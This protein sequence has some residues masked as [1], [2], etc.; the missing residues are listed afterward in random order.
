MPM[1]NQFLL[2]KL[3]RL[4]QFLFFTSIFSAACALVLCW[5]SECLFVGKK[6]QLFSVLHVFVVA[7]TLVV[8]NVHYLIKKFTAP[9]S[10]QN[11]WVQGN[12]HFNYIFLGLGLLLSG[13]FAFQLPSI[14]WPICLV[15]A[16]LSFAYSLPFLP[17]K[18]KH[19]LKDYGW[20]KIFLLS[21]VWTCVTALLPLVYHQQIL[22]HY[23]FD[24]L[25]RFVFLFI[26]CLAFDIRDRAVDLEAGILTIPNRMGLAKTYRL[27]AILCILYI[28]LAFVQYF[29]F[30]F[31]DRLVI[32]LLTAIST[33][34]AIHFV[35]RHPS[36]KNYILFID[37]QMLLNGLLILMFYS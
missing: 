21:V 29:R 4:V 27:I 31:E 12:K 19:R 24:I 5:A 15:L 20:L 34:G 10:D 17:F 2:K 13:I 16:L 11:A 37:G 1:F 9:L 30:G 28:L 32:H 22:S 8:Y 14:M 3:D 33:F 6:T 25:L 26:L 18:N 35:G 36:D 23:P 7:G